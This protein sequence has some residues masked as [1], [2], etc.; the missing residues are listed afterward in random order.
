MVLFYPPS[1]MRLLRCAH[2]DTH[3]QLFQPNDITPA[4]GWI[5]GFKVVF[6]GIGEYFGFTFAI[7]LCV[8]LGADDD[9][10]GAVAFV[11]AESGILSCA[12]KIMEI[13]YSAKLWNHKKEKRKK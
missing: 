9:G 1:Q 7:L 5:L 13:I 10:F 11:D 8:L 6:D 12:A 3:Q 2:S 4:G